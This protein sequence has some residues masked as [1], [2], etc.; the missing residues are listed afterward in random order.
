MLKSIYGKYTKITIAN[1]SKKVK[2]KFM[3]SPLELGSS[4]ITI[5][6]LNYKCCL[7]AEEKDVV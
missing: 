6:H 7:S 2:T 1:L 5:F 3:M 4:V